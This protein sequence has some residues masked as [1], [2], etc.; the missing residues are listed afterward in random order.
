MTFDN[1]IIGA[2][3]IDIFDSLIN[4]KGHGTVATSLLIYFKIAH[5]VGVFLPSAESAEKFLE[6][7]YVWLGGGGR[8]RR[9]TYLE[10]FTFYF[11][12]GGGMTSKRSN[13]GNPTSSE[14][15]R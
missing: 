8:R 13:N 2:H 10:E 4:L 14:P 12:V 6:E 7:G 15:A 9:T 3:R 11:F 1:G 5:T